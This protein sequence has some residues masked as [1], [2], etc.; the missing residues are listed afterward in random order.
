MNIVTIISMSVT[1]PALTLIAVTIRNV[2]HSTINNTVHAVVD[3]FQNVVLV[4]D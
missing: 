3:S 2:P 4:V 1:Q